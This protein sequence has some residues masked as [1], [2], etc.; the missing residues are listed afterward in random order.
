[1]DVLLNLRSDLGRQ[2][3]IEQA[4]RE[5]IVEGQLG[6]GAPLPSTRVLAAELGVAR[7]TVVAAI[8][9][10]AAEGLLETRPGS[11]TRVAHVPPRVIDEPPPDE[12]KRPRP[13][14]ADFWSGDPDLTLFPRSSWSAAVRTALDTAE[15]ATLGYGDP[16][17][18]LE[19]RT[20]VA[21]YAARTRGV[22]ASPQRTIVTAG[23]SQTLAVLGRVLADL[24][25]RPVA[26]E[27]PS[28][29]LHREL[30][31]HAGL[32]CAGVVVDGEGVRTE[33][34]QATGAGAAFVTPGHHTPLGVSLSP[35]RRVRLVGWAAAADAVIVEDDYDGELRYD[36]RPLRAVQA[37]DPARVVYCGTASKSLA[38]GLRLAWCVLPPW[39]LEPAI[40]ALA[41]IGGPSVSATEQL[42]LADLLRSGRYD[43]QVRRARDEYHR[44][45]DLLVAAI[46]RHAP[47]IRVEGVDAGLKALLRLPPGSDEH[48]V[49]D[50]LARRSVAVAPLSA[51]QID[52][53]DPPTGPAV[54]V[55]YGRPY[56]HD[57]RSAVDRLVTGLAAILRTAGSPA[58]SARDDRAQ[59]SSESA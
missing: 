18:N 24:D 13:P 40:S 37:L 57:Y 1:V 51:F 50:Q 42:A 49:V 19:L 7:G 36:R 15:A 38:P 39:L 56:G 44:R 23:Y 11:S 28:F 12:A 29:W 30:L 47:T 32:T 17:G 5:A 3:A 35:S 54:V 26:V 9:Q 59:S 43:R 33:E 8:D 25:D 27:D 52:R 34:L 14:S 53:A 22:V 20:N 45:R 46:E 31:A 48:A 6:P 41:A 10:L 2:A 55:N 4:V 58:V 21:E 16:R